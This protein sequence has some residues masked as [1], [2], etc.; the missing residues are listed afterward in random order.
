MN[1]SLV[2]QEEEDEEEQQQQQRLHLPAPPSNRIRSHSLKPRHSK[3]DYVRRKSAADVASIT[4]KH[5]ELSATINK[6]EHTNTPPPRRPSATWLQRRFT[7]FSFEP[8]ELKSNQKRRMTTHRFS[9][10]DNGRNLLKRKR[11]SV[12]SQMVEVFDLFIDK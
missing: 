6:L 7:V 8:E 12:I 2:T 11:P 10:F 4:P 5:L 1:S 3:Q 9:I